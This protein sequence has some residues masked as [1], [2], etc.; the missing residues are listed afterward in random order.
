MKQCSKLSV[1]YIKL[2]SAFHEHRLSLPTNICRRGTCNL[3]PTSLRPLS[4]R[5][6][7]LV[8]N[9]HTLQERYRLEV[10]VTP[11]PLH[12]FQST[13]LKIQGQSSRSVINL[14]S[15]GSRFEL[16]QYNQLLV[17][18]LLFVYDM[19]DNISQISPMFVTIHSSPSKT[20]FIAAA[21]V[22]S[23]QTRVRD[24]KKSV[25]LLL[26]ATQPRV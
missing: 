17:P 23:L 7:K 14:L 2:P 12:V 11:L 8:N 15:E 4:R 6:S 10:S 22:Q 9:W 5:A 3:I 1:T 16:R 24:P 20:I 19:H 25:I 18:S 13:L 26:A 21:V